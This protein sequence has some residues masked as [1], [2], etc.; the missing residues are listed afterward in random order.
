MESL[1]PASMLVPFE[2]WLKGFWAV[3]T[4][5]PLFAIRVRVGA[6]KS[7][8]SGCVWFFTSG[9]VNFRGLR[10]ECEQERKREIKMRKE[11]ILSKLTLN[12]MIL[13]RGA[14]FKC[15]CSVRQKKYRVHSKV[16]LIR[17][18][19]PCFIDNGKQRDARGINIEKRWFY[20]F[21]FKW[22]CVS[23][24]SMK[25]LLTLVYIQR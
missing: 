23:F 24:H 16:H 15:F 6:N 13:M 14:Q 20:I 19:D 9:M 1:I 18:D 22:N 3:E 5:F 10:E 25:S 8:S 12:W 21:F 11:I 2:R 4:S 17:F 7:S